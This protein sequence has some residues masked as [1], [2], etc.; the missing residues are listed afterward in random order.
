[1]GERANRPPRDAARLAGY[2]KRNLFALGMGLVRGRLS[3]WLGLA[4][5]VMVTVTFVTFAVIMA[6][7]DRLSAASLPA[8]A[9]EVLA[10]GPGMLIA[11]AGSLHALRNDAD[12]GIFA[13]VQGRGVPVRAFVVQRV[14]SLGVLLALTAALGTASVALAASIASPSTDL[15]MAS[16]HA[17]FAGVVHGI[18]FGAVMGPVAMATLG[19]RSRSGGYIALVLVLALPELLRL[20]AY[21]LPS[22]W[23]ELLSIPSCLATLRSALSPGHVEGG[24]AIGA[25]VVLA[26]AAL[27]ATAFAVQQA[28]SALANRSRAEAA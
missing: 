5:A 19:A 7:R 9:S 3:V 17:G 25:A 15:T 20:V 11:F 24:R 8:V 22:A 13:L 1:M 28:T 21:D 4:F 23:G 26:L 12:Q 27:L 14:L 16:L 6:S 10:W 2:R 18:A